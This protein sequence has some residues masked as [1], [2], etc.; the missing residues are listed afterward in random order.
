M[1][2]FI[3]IVFAMFTFLGPILRPLVFVLIEELIQGIFSFLLFDPLFALYNFFGAGNFSG[4]IALFV[5]IGVIRVFGFLGFLGMAIL[6]H[7]L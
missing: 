2:W 1:F 6:A 5:Y 7:F 4:I 3:L